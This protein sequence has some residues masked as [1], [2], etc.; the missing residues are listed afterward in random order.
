MLSWLSS[1]TLVLVLFPERAFRP[2]FQ[3]LL[4]DSGGEQLKKLTRIISLFVLLVT[5]AVAGIAATPAVLAKPEPPS[6]HATQNG[7]ELVITWDRIPGAQYYTVGWIN[8]TEG[9]P[10]YSAGGDWLSYFNY[11]TV[12]GDRTSYTVQGLTGGDDYYANIRATD[13]PGDDVGRFGGGWSTFSAWPSSPAQPARGIIGLPTPESEYLSEGDTATFDQYSVT[14]TRVTTPQ[15]VRWTR[16]DGTQYDR[17]PPAG[18]RWLIIAMH[19]DNGRDGRTI[20]TRGL[21]FFVG[22][23]LGGGFSWTYEREVDPGNTLDTDLLFDVPLNATTVDLVLRPYTGDVPQ[24]FRITIPEPPTATV[25]FGDLNWS[26]ALVQTRIAQYIVEK[27]YGYPTDLR[28]GRTLSL[29]QGLRSGETDVLMELWLPNQEEAWNAATAAGEVVSLG[30]SLGSDW[31]SAF[32]IPAYLQEQYPGLDSVEDLK[33]PQ[34]RQ[35]FSTAETGDKARLV[36]CPIG[37]SCEPLN[38]AQVEGYG[39]SDYVH[40]VN[41]VDGPA[42]DADLHGA[43]EREEPWLGYQ[44]GT[45]GP[46]LLLDLVR[47]QEPPYTDACWATT[48]ACAYEDATILIA[49]HYALRDTAPEVV[50]MLRKWDFPVDPVYKQIVRWQAANPNADFNATAV[51]WLN[52]H[53]D[54]WEQWVTGE[55]A[56]SIRAALATDEIPDGWPDG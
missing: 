7:G 6:V 33:D 26:S 16:S 14:V 21:D 2:D 13:V 46:A 27:G 5:F 54:T 22:T 36:S 37:W 29:F 48:K 55:A 51:W 24:L 11:T 35:L 49:A 47:L 52:N 12:K 40:I 56:T 3:T 53:A 18:R 38:A 10:V 31:Q 34:Y 25:V 30:G 44:W 45:N 17:E 28:F 20:L 9:Q 4:A 15:T 19:L 41:P 23:E 32:V 42:L 8:W 43:Y 1:P 39:L 50:E